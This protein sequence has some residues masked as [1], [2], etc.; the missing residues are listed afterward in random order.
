MAKIMAKI[1][2]KIIAKIMAKIMAKTI[3]KTMVVVALGCRASGSHNFPTH[4][5]AWLVSKIGACGT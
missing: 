5:C 4:H 1:I 2:A 3:A